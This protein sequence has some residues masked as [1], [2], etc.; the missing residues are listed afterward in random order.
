MA[1]HLRIH[2]IVQGVGY[3]ASFDAQARAL[4]LTGW[5]RNRRDGSVEAM[6]RGEQGALEQ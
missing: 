3:R 6:V 1:K 2:G 5:V 4:G